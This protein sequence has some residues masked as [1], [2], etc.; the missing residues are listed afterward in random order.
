MTPREDSNVK[1]EWKRLGVENEVEK[2]PIHEE[3]GRPG[4]D[5]LGPG[6]DLGEQ[7]P[8]GMLPLLPEGDFHVVPEVVAHNE[9]RD[10]P[11]REKSGVSKVRR[12]FEVFIVWNKR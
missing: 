7:F 10:A 4:D 5:A 3:G 11:D 1:P 6:P 8:S 12:L 9:E 2:F